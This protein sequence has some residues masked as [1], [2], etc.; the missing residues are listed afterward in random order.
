M[1]SRPYR[2]AIPLEV[3]GKIDELKSSGFSSITIAQAL[4]VHFQTV[5]NA[6]KRR[7]AYSNIPKGKK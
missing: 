7:G 4:G 5:R 2:L 6:L 3:V 1:C